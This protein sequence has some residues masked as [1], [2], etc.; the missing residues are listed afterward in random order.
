MNEKFTEFSFTA[1]HTHYIAK[2]KTQ[3]QI[4]R[5]RASNWHNLCSPMSFAHPK[6]WH[7]SVR[8]R[9]HAFK[10]IDVI[11]FTATLKWITTHR[12]I[13]ISYSIRYQRKF[14]HFGCE[15]LQNR[16]DFRHAQ[17][18]LNANLIHFHWYK[19]TK[20][21]ESKTKIILTQIFQSVSY[22]KRTEQKP[23]QSIG[24]KIQNIITI[25]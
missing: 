15:T 9:S 23:L 25:V 12:T 11:W 1:T 17:K 21:T 5:Q 2:G 6:A 16:K 7:A 20:N 18:H 4:E 8:A 19:K 13:L 24:K 22:I 10:P 3:R 14:I